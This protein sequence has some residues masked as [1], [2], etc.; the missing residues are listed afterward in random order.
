MCTYIRW[1]QNFL[2]MNRKKNS[3]NW[4]FLLLALSSLTLFTS[5]EDEEEEEI[6]ETLTIA[7]ALASDFDFTI[8]NEALMRTDLMSDLDAQ[9]SFTLLA[10]PDEAFINAGITN[11][12]RF[13]DEELTEILQYHV[14]AGDVFYSDFNTRTV[15]TL[16]G[17]IY[18]SSNAQR[19]YLN[20]ETNFVQ[21]NYG[22]SNGVIHSVDRV[23]MPPQNSVVQLVTEDDDL[24]IAQA[25]IEKAGLVSTLNGD[26]PFTIFVPTDYAFN[27]LFEE[28]GVNGIDE[29]SSTE[30]ANILQYHAIESRS[31][32]TDLEAGMQPTTLEG[33]SFRVLFDFNIFLIDEND[34]NDNARIVQDNKLG[35]NGVIHKINRVLLS[36]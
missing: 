27:I 16:N 9:G 4:L 6:I 14:I 21:I 5:C 13:T 11:L 15:E 32:S 7:D 23:L 34:T 35:T 36:E 2:L 28:L 12:D 24:T 18:V 20:G 1:L 22:A 33:E 19:I 10:P 17:N 25:A 8:L 29:I 30:L 31:F 3:F 26:G